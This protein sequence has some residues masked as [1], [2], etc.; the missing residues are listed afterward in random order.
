M[1]H[2]GHPY[3]GLWELTL[4]TTHLRANQVQGEDKR[5]SINNYNKKQKFMKKSIKTKWLKALRSGKYKQGIGRLNKDGKMCCLGVLCDL[6]TKE[7]GIK[8]IESPL[9]RGA[10]VIQDHVA[11]PPIS[12]QKWSGLYNYQQVRN[13]KPTNLYILNDKEMKSFK[14]IAN[15]IEK[16]L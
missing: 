2:R 11:L 16:S 1:K 5:G 3:V 9:E 4:N 7:K 8:W 12:V 10:F 15:L 13:S 14:Q 6:Y